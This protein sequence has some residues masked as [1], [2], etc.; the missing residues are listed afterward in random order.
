[1]GKHH[2]FV[3]KSPDFLYYDRS[4]LWALF[5]VKQGKPA[6]NYNLRSKTVSHDGMLQNLKLNQILVEQLRNL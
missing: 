5:Q 6:M 4:S 1:M 3:S 2:Q